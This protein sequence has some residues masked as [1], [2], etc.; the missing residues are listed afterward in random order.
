MLSSVICRF[1]GDIN[2]GTDENVEAGTGG[3]PKIRG[4]IRWEK[5]KK[6][7]HA[8]LESALKKVHEGIRFGE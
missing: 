8:V 7:R 3:V 5:P 1:F 4:D 6:E 2:S